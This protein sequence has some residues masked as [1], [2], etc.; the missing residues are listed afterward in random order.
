[1]LKKELLLQQFVS[2]W[3]KLTVGSRNGLYGFYSDTYNL[4]Y[5]LCGSLSDRSFNGL[6][7]TNILTGISSSPYPGTRVRFYDDAV[8]PERALYL[9]RKDKDVILLT[10]R[11]DE[12]R[13]YANF[14]VRDYFTEQDIGKTIDIY[15]G[16]TPP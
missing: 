10:Y 9:K 6:T 8:L 16:T 11:R 5:I 13:Y 14:D 7:I 12:G 3:R 4:N 2:G 1:M 15:L